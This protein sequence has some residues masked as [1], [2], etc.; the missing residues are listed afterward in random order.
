MLREVV[1]IKEKRIDYGKSFTQMAKEGGCEEHW[2]VRALDLAHWEKYC[3]KM[4]ADGYDGKPLDIV[5]LANDAPM[6]SEEVRADIGKL[7]L[8]LGRYEHLV[9]AGRL[10]TNGHV[11]ALGTEMTFADAG[12]FAKLPEDPTANF[13]GKL[14]R[15]KYVPGLDIIEGHRLVLTLDEI[16]AE[17]FGAK[18]LEE[19]PT[20]KWPAGTYFIAVSVSLEE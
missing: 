14:R 3:A 11:V 18:D 10:Y 17:N 1:T 15:K 19:G 13:S 5:V 4:K 6:T 2:F 16:D 7:A 20:V 8:E 9:A 12:M